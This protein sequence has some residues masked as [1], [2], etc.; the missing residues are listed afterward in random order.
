M[1]TELRVRKAVPEYD[2]TL[3]SHMIKKKDYQYVGQILL[4][5]Q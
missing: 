1:S 3:R 2:G 4:K 5:N